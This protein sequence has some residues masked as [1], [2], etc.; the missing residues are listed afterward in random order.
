VLVLDFISKPNVK[1]I[2]LV[3]VNAEE[4]VKAECLLKFYGF[5]DNESSEDCLESTE[6]L[7]R[8]IVLSIISFTLPPRV[9]NSRTELSSSRPFSRK[10]QRRFRLTNLKLNKTLEDKKI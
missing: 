10:K 2:T 3:L 9:I 8:S 1:A 7:R 4:L 6:K 5:A